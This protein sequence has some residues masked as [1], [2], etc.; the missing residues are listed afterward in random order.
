MTDERVAVRRETA[1]LASLMPDH[2]STSE[3]FGDVSDAR[4]FP[5]EEAVIERSVAK[6]RDEFTTVRWCAREALR[7]IGVAA[8][9][10]LPGLRG[11]PQWPAGV[12]G[13][14]THC[15]GYRGAVVARAEHLVTLGIDAEPDAALPDGILAAVASQAEQDSLA[16]LHAEAAG[17]S[18]DRLLFSAKE[19]VYKAWFPLTATWLDFDEASVEFAA[20]A[21]RSSGTFRATLLV[22]GPETDQGRITGFDGLWLR[23][24]GILLTAIAVPRAQDRS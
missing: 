15:E 22:P 9:P 10:I 3:C 1:A 2:V 5:A 21:D 19:S 13:S 20:G 8:V 7:N 6:R 23:H 11:A 16:H 4:L 14:M 18:W 24:R 12:V 17:P